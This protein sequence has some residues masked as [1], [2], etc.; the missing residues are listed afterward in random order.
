[1]SVLS[2]C[3]RQLSTRRHH[4]ARNL[5]PLLLAEG[6][7]LV[8]LDYADANAHEVRVSHAS[9]GI[10]AGESRDRPAHA[11]LPRTQRAAH[12]RRFRRPRGSAGAAARSAKLSRP[13]LPRP[14]RAESFARQSLARR[15][16]WPPAR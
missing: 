16:R 15:P 3:T 10:Q 1:H 5:L 11:P 7:V 4:A 8:R 12:G 6:A 2:T 14:R 9:E 13:P